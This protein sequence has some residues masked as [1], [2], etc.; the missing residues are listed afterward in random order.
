M[1]AGVLLHVVEPPGPVDAAVHFRICW[2]AVDDVTDFL[3]FI[4]DVEDIGVANLAQ[5]VRL[6]A[7]R[8]VKRRAIKNQFPDGSRDSGVHI[9]REHFA[10]HHPRREFLFKC[11][12]VIKSARGHAVTPMARTGAPAA[13]L[14]RICSR[15]RY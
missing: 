9:R 8:G 6:A 7:G 10:I 3:A 11:I 12:V 4:A 13:R 5:I 15:C 14:R 2:A 1:L